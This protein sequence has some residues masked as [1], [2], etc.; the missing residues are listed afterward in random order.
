[1]IN[2]KLINIILISIFLISLIGCKQDVNK[3][4]S[5][6]NLMSSMQSVENFNNGV[7]ED[8]TQQEIAEKYGITKEDIEEGYV[9]Y[10]NNEERSDKIILI[11]A[12]DK[13]NIESV[14]R[15]VSSE[16][17]GITDS[18]KNNKDESEK[19][20]SHIFK[21]RDLYVLMYIGENV[22]K[23]ENIFD[24]TVNLDS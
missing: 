5:L 10:P 1:M 6:K 14:E 23:I 21:T 2:K 4:I 20:A 8:L 11:K 9:Y 15:S 7:L 17:I 12:K 19:I 24:N 3:N 16:I 18:W 22:D 13:S